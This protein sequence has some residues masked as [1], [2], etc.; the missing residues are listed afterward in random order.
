M[1]PVI[2]YVVITP[3]RNERA[4][5]PRTIASFEAQ[6]L[7]PARWV[8]VDDGST[9]GT[10]E[11]V[12]A[13]AARH[14]WIT[15]VHRADRGFRQPGTG[16][17]E[18]FNEGLAR[19]AGEPFEYMVKFDADLDFAP[20]YFERCFEKFAENPRL[21][22]GGG[23]ICRRE[24]EGLVVESHADPAFHVRGATK[25]YRRACWDQLGGLVKAPGWDTIDEL[26]ASMLGWETTTFQDLKI[27]QLKDTGSADGNW[28]NWVKNGLANYNSGYHPLFM[29]AKCGRR[30]FR[31]PYG[32]G[33]CALAWGFVKGCL[34][35]SPRPLEPE[36]I[37]YVQRQQLNRLL[38]KDSLWS[39]TRTGAGAGSPSAARAL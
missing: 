5:V 14:P 30:L 32:L 34:S 39:E 13:A 2:P 12:D 1:S 7:L 33:G 20:D 29:A 28:R 25:I 9:D 23:A 18:A 26:K 27:H 19:V 31:R 4:N 10:S 24:A 36:L 3:V 6:T 35:G 11:L 38:G 17:V 21:G 16:V 8:I 15:A 22:I 37:R